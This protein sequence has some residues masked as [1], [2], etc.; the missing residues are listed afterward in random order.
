MIFKLRNVNHD[1]FHSLGA[2]PWE[3]PETNI[4][5]VLTVEGVLVHLFLTTNYL[6]FGDTHA[7][8]STRRPHH[9]E[10]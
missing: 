3:I 5:Q 10:Y 9:A 2:P 8:H 7:T 6:C 1:N 4:F